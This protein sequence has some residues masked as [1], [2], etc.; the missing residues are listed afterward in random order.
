MARRALVQCTDIFVESKIE[1][2]DLARKLYSAEVIS[3]DMYKRV[4]DTQCRDTNKE[5][6]EK[7]LDE[8]KDRVKN[9]VSILTILFKIL[10]DLKRKDLADIISTKYKGMYYL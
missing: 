6:L 2:F 7:I 4:R 5:R 8:L 9:N 3:E 10:N 1:S